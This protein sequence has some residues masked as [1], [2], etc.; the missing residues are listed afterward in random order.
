MEEKRMS[1]VKKWMT[2]LQEIYYVE[3]FP[4]DG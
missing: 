4:D 3:I 1:E 2:E